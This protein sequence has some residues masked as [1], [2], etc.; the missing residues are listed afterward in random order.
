MADPTAAYVTLTWIATGCY[1]LG[2]FANLHGVLFQHA[3]T[4]RLARW[5][6]GIGMAVHAAAIAFWWRVVGHGPYMA[7]SEVLSSDAWVALACFFGFRAFFPRIQPASVVVFPA[8]ML[9]LALSVF[10]NPGIRSLPATFGSVW[11]VFH[12]AFYKIAVG[13]LLIAVA[14]SSFLLAKGRSRAAWLAKLPDPERLD[15]YAYRF[16]GFGFVFWGIA[17]LAGSIWAYNSWGRYWGWDPVETWALVT[18]LL[19]GIY[20]HLR[21]FFRWTGRRAAWLLVAC[22]VV[23]LVS[24]FVTSHMSTSIHAEYFR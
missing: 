7:P 15:L 1:A 5:P 2:T 20:L 12:I 17:M 24:V 10:Q 4:E 23:S 22:F 21:R 18:W 6:I 11:L 13:T 9:L 8:A 14:F 3:R 16:T 19:F